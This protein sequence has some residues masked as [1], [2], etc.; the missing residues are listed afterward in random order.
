MK[1]TI[2]WYILHIILSSIC[3]F[4]ITRKNH[5]FV[6]KIVNTLLTKHFWAVFALAERLPTSA[7][8]VL[9]HK[10]NQY[11]KLNWKKHKKRFLRWGSGSEG[12]ALAL[13]GGGGRRPISAIGKLPTLPSP[14]VYHQPNALLCNVLD[15]FSQMIHNQSS[16]K[17]W[18]FY[19]YHKCHTCSEVE[20][21]DG[22]C[23][24]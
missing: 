13:A 3:K 16:Q 14:N 17:L 8:L 9:H 10:K 6:A 12:L 11:L 23:L 21:Q 5:A 24:R 7:T 15:F 18:L 22:W 4:A 20:S 1:C 2:T 19:V